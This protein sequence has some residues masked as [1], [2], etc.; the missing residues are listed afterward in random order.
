MHTGKLSRW[1]GLG[2][3]LNIS[4]MVWRF[5]AISDSL[6]AL[7]PYRTVTDWIRDPDPCFWLIF[8]GLGFIGIQEAVTG[9]RRPL[10]FWNV[11]YLV[12]LIPN[13]E[14]LKFGRWSPM[15]LET[16]LRYPGNLVS[17][18]WIFGAVIAAIAT[19]IGHRRMIA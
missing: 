15:S 13:W 11:V 10:L 1:L 5:W 4:I 3:I 7:L 16:L 6:I 18:I 9:D 2:L 12:L 8:Y 14:D 17:R 19:Y